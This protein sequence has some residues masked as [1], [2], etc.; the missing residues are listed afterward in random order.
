MAR[1]GK[2]IKKS[3]QNTS[4]KLSSTTKKFKSNPKTLNNNAAVKAA[5]NAAATSIMVG[6]VGNDGVVKVVQ[7]GEKLVGGTP[8]SVAAEAAKL[9]AEAA[10]AAEA[11]AK[12]AEDKTTVDAAKEAA[13]AA[14]EAEKA[15]EAAQAAEAA[16]EAEA[17]RQA[18]AAAR[19]A[20]LEAEAAQAAEAAA[21]NAEDKTTVDAAKEAAEAAKKAVNLTKSKHVT[22]YMLHANMNIY[23]NIWVDNTFIKENL[24]ITKQ[25]LD[26]AE[27]SFSAANAYFVAIN[28]V[29]MDA[30][31]VEALKSAAK[32]AYGDAQNKKD[33][34]NGV[35]R[36][37]MV[38]YY[39][40]SK[41]FSSAKN[42]YINAH[43][44]IFSS[45]YGYALYD[46]QK[47][48]LKEKGLTVTEFVK[49][50]DIMNTYS[51]ITRHIKNITELINSI[52]NTELQK[53][54]QEQYIDY[55][56]VKYNIDR[57]M[58]MKILKA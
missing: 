34:A 20:E 15:A 48:I 23:M 4:G 28:D 37:V 30:H 1:K 42:K 24:D 49:L 5:A 31:A 3:R 32:T 33:K 9:E 17:A 22:A 57:T 18:E 46:E 14:K 25:Y 44:S 40:T 47:R 51:I 50:P 27:K 45:K 38:N 2:T 41:L 8:S 16:R 52:S 58:L 53:K 6:G 35:E 56:A 10:Q 39:E 43:I 12:N 11:A 21:K 29:S 36:S 54:W 7:E 26:A 19:E 55:H 13:K